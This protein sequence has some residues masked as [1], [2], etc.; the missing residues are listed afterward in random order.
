MRT[1][2]AE[3]DCVQLR[4]A[5]LARL[6]QTPLVIDAQGHAAGLVVTVQSS[7][8]ST[9]RMVK[10]TFPAAAAKQ[11]PGTVVKDNGGRAR[12]G[13]PAP[14]LLEQ[15]EHEARS[16]NLGSTQGARSSRV[17]PRTRTRGCRRRG[18]DDGA[19]A[20]MI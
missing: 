18:R 1:G 5:L 8:A 16:I 6:R 4:P 19:A 7:M 10:Q 9:S 11:N 20:W 17:A 2:F 15:P 12:S 3:E 13:G 14:L